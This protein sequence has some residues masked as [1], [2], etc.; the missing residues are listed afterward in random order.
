M[1]LCRIWS[2]CLCLSH[3]WHSFDP[4]SVALWT[5]RRRWWHRSACVCICVRSLHS[6]SRFVRCVR[7]CICMCAHRSCSLRSHETWNEDRET[8]V[9]CLWKWTNRRM[10]SKRMFDTVEGGVSFPNRTYVYTVAI[11]RSDANCLLNWTSI[12]RRFMYRRCDAMAKLC[13]WK[14][15]YLV[16]IW[17]FV[18][19]K[20]IGTNT[21][22]NTTNWQSTKWKIKKKNRS[23]NL[24]RAWNI[25]WNRM[26][27]NF[28]R[29]PTSNYRVNEST[30]FFYFSSLSSSSPSFLLLFWFAWLCCRRRCSETRFLLL[31][32]V[33]LRWYS[34][35]YATANVIFSMSRHENVNQ[36][37][38]NFRIGRQYLPDDFSHSLSRRFASIAF[39][40]RF[41]IIIFFARRQRIRWLQ[42]YLHKPNNSRS[43]FRQN[44]VSGLCAQFFRSFRASAV[45]FFSAVEF[46]LCLVCVRTVDWRRQWVNSLTQQR[47]LHRNAVRYLYR[48]DKQRK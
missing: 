14:R 37:D 39:W 6:N 13:D 20:S 36:Q 23:E 45:A 12:M 32:R 16:E 24:T 28:A 10:R 8:P 3:V 44:W 2:F 35:S 4:H 31:Q 17:N 40:F 46:Q 11:S 15:L 42:K 21:S 5:I 25:L 43:P 48:K 22:A 34:I 19:R 30:V 18:A 33:F 38:E 47:V 41:H 29:T 1:H 26:R 9:L 27:S 7:L